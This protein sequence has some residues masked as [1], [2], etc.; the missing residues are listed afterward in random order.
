MLYSIFCRYV[1]RVMR[2]CGGMSVTVRFYDRELIAT[3][4]ESNALLL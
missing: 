2:F 1:L 4:V 3:F